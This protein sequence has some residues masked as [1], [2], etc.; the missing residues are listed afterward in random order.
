MSIVIDSK[1]IMLISS[2]LRNFKQKKQ[3]LWNFSCP[4]C[5][6]SRKN[7]SKARGYVYEKVSKL[8]YS[9]HN[10]GAS[11]NVANLLKSVDPNLHKQYVLERYQT[12][13][14]SNTIFKKSTTSVP[15]TRFGKVEKTKT[16][17]HAE[18]VE[19]LED[20]H[21]CLDYIKQRKIPKSFYSK[22]LFTSKYSDFVTNIFPNHG[23]QIVNDARLVIPFYNEYND[24][25]AV[26]GR[27]LENN[28]NLLRY[29]TIKSSEND[30]KI[31]YGLDRIDTTKTVKIVEGP[32][33]SMFLDNCVASG[34]ANL[35]LTANNIFAS[36]KVLIFDNQPRNKEIVKMMQKA[37]KSKHNVVIWPNTV[38][39]KDINEMIMSGISPSQI[40]KII[41]NNTVYGLEAQTNFIFW[42]KV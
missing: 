33:D 39:G 1:Y 24:L 34:D 18:W 37:I 5:G 3:N 23:K 13:E 40:E 36:K 38:K 2:R 9:C 30:N 27:S 4:L 28:T 11:T 14:N 10:C 31:V 17:E 8:F 16:F 41:Y 22:L 20:R 29:V 42:K 15:T 26:S 25:I 21:F 6:D 32:I 35:T 19:N 12:G 7:K